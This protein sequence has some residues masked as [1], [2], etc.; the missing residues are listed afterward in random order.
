M[1][2]LH[3]ADKW[4]DLLVHAWR[5]YSRERMS[6][7]C[8]RLSFDGAA[9]SALDQGQREK[10]TTLG[11]QISRTWKSRFWA[12]EGSGDKAKGSEVGVGVG[13]GP[14]EYEYEYKPLEV[15]Q[16]TL[17]VFR[18]NLMH[19][20]GANPSRKSRIAYT[21]SIINGEGRVSR[22][23]LYESCGGGLWESIIRL[24][25]RKK[26]VCVLWFFFRKCLLKTASPPSYDSS[27]YLPSTV[28]RGRER[29]REKEKNW[30]KDGEKEKF[31]I[32]EDLC[33][34]VIHM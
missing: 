7:G 31:F 30:G 27:S 1:Y 19:T 26:Y 22:R 24:R 28:Y 12:E 20:S 34:Q 21:F 17:V 6:F 15:K 8:T 4:D 11:C 10:K 16:G 13:V 14:L 18:G 32:H 23:Q 29:E 2:Q 5:C 25:R 9:K 3:Q 33:K